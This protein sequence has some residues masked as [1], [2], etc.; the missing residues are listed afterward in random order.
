MSTSQIE[1][2]MPA[3]PVG[4]RMHYPNGALAARKNLALRKCVCVLKHRNAPDLLIE[5]MGEAYKVHDFA[6][7]CHK[8]YGWTVV[9]N[10]KGV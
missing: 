3:V 6:E 5:L 7:A 10:F 8:R 2:P 4:V 9:R 1:P